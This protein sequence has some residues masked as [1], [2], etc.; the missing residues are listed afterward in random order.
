MQLEERII[1]PYHFSLLFFTE[2]VK[3]VQKV[4]VA[5]DSTMVCF[6]L[7]RKGLKG[8][9]VREPLRQCYCL[10]LL[11]MVELIE[12][13][14]AVV[15]EQFEMLEELAAPAVS[16][17]VVDSYQEGTGVVEANVVRAVVVACTVADDHKDQLLEVVA[18]ELVVEG[19]H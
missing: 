16:G 13:G 4:A 19:V 9:L 7:P 15:V 18:V 17:S 1:N 10:V 14:V 5:A 6:A 3:F 12:T 2:Q 11:Q 8:E